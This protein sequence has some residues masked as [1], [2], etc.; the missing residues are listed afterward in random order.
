MD[1][2]TFSQAVT[3]SDAAAKVGLTIALEDGVDAERKDVAALLAI[4]AKDLAGDHEAVIAEMADWMASTRCGYAL[5][6]PV[7]KAPLVV[8]VARSPRNGAGRAAAAEF[9]RALVLAPA[10]LRRLPGTA[11]AL[12]RQL[13]AAG[14]DADGFSVAEAHATRTP[15]NLN[16]RF[17]DAAEVFGMRLR[18]VPI[19]DYLD[20]V[21][22]DGTFLKDKFCEQPF[23]MYQVDPVGNV[24]ICCP[25]YMPVMAGSARTDETSDLFNSPS[26]LDV[27]RSILNG[28]F[29]YCSR[30]RCPHIRNR[31]LPKRSEVS[32]P[33]FR[34][35]ID[36]HDPVV[37]TVRHTVLSYDATCN[38]S[39]PS[40]RS[41]LIVDKGAER[42][43]K[44]RMTAN[45][46]MPLLHRSERVTMNGY[47]DIFSS[48]I[49]RFILKSISPATAPGLK[50]DFLT[51]GV[52]LTERTWKEFSHMNAMVDR[53]MVSVDAAREETYDVVRR[54]G[55]FKKL[56]A[57]LSFIS[58]LRRDGHISG[59]MMNFVYQRENFREMKDFVHWAIDLGCDEV[60]FIELLDWNSF[61]RDDYLKNAVH[62][63]ENPL[64][65]EFADI[66]HDPIFHHPI[67]TLRP[68]I[69]GLGRENDPA[70]S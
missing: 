49:C 38:L 6:T 68:F 29:R 55:D 16:S 5:R 58:R 24:A 28:D 63:P 3:I 21:L 41:G 20:D 34:N 39:C 51:N 18:G 12:C 40:C 7:E 62:L 61:A 2:A 8:T 70:E 69:S 22:G 26:A 48:R 1:G 53:I 45:V 64:H 13:Y 33:L 14:C 52:L 25:N 42:D 35:A 19:P 32:D 37:P 9:L 23:Q 44:M 47:G 54:G 60:R 50:V 59:F 17:V 31:R 27:R 43:W 15:P 65:H 56:Q 30:A 11:F 36:S 57:N 46:I 67:V 66:I 10:F 4:L